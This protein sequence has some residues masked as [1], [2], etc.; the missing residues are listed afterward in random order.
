MVKETSLFE[1]FKETARHGIIFGV[2]TVLQKAITFILL[3]LYTTRFSASEYGTLGLI[4]I[5]GSVLVTICTLGVNFGLFR[6]YYDYENEEDRKIV[7]STALFIILASSFVL[8]ILGL[9]FSKHLSFLVFGNP[10]YE[11]HFLMIMGISIFTMLNTIPFVIFRAQKKSI[12]YIIFRISFFIIAVALI[13]YLVAVKNWGIL[14]V[15]TGSLT[16][17]A[18]SCLTL[19]FYIRKEIVL[20][21]LKIEA[22]KMLRFGLPLIPANLS[23]FVFNSTDRYFLNYFSTLHELGL[24]NL[25][26]KL[27]TV[28]TVLLA[29]PIALIWPAM[30]LS[31]RKHS[32]AKTFY[33]KALTYIVFLSLL[34]FLGLSLLSK[35]VLQIF[36]NKQYWDAYKVI[37]IITLTYALWTLPKITNVAISLKRKTKAAA[38]IFFLGAVVNI[39]LNFALIPKYGMMGAAYA[40]FITYALMVAILFFYNQR[41]MGVS[42]EWNRIFKMAIIAALIFMLGYFVVI[43]NLAMS[44]VFKLIIILLL[45]PLFL[46]LIRFYTEG[47]IRRVKQIWN[48]VTAKAKIK[49]VH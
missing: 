26:Y 36:S 12:Q 1:K 39:G 4:T 27:G 29:S 3:P 25:G 16:M 42:Y 5:T 40:T 47:E 41:L 49:R 32:N 11:V 34:M 8:F 28:I 15:L 22:R 46:Y 35:E 17:E 43:D 38:M 21:F 45:Y 20:K 6:S 44:I 13:I 18:I 2:G 7:I 10:E 33:V 31:V 23:V 48:Y 19:Y 24:Y 37:P 9:I 14:G 30:F